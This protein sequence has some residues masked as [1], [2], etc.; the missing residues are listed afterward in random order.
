MS[1]E[2]PPRRPTLRLHDESSESGNYDF[3]TITGAQK[4]VKEISQE[5]RRE[6]RRKSKNGR[7]AMIA[8]VFGLGGASATGVYLSDLMS[9]FAENRLNLE[10]KQ[11]AKEAHDHLNARIDEIGAKLDDLPAKVAAEVRRKK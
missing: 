1:E 6:M 11:E 4:V 3:N 2:S 10:S 5:L 7:V 9:W 8:A